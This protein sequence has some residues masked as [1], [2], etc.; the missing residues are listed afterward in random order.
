MW[1]GAPSEWTRV[2]VVF[3]L[4][5]NGTVMTTAYTKK[6][7]DVDAEYQ[8]VSGYLSYNVNELYTAGDTL[9]VCLYSEFGGG[10]SVM[11]DNVVIYTLKPVKS[12][13]VKNQ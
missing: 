5:K 6:L 11:F 9:N 1:S 4:N 13:E 8:V 12:K 10:S 3:S 7:A 2:K